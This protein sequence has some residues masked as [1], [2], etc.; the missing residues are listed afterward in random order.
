MAYR[1]S[2]QVRWKKLDF[3]TGYEVMLSNSHP[4]TDICDEMVGK[5]PKTFVF[6]GWHPNCYCY[7][8]PILMEQDDF[9]KY[10]ETEKIPRELKVKGI[11]ARAAV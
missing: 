6:A 7:T 4:V 1:T 2:D 8:V 3:V 9:I 10:L 11:P 5:Y